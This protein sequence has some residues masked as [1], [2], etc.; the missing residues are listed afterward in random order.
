MRGEHEKLAL[1]ARADFAAWLGE[2]PLEEVVR[3]KR[4]EPAGLVP[5]SIAVARTT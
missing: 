5:E 4:R 1:V 2:T 3:V